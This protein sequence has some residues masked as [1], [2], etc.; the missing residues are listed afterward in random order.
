ME[1]K[2]NDKDKVKELSNLD[3]IYQAKTITIPCSGE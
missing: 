2:D 1:E 3:F